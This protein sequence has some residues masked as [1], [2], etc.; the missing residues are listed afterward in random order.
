MTKTNDWPRTEELAKKTQEQVRIPQF[1]RMVKRPGTA[2]Y[3]RNQIKVNT[4][5]TKKLKA[6][7]KSALG[8]NATSV[9]SPGLN[10]KSNSKSRTMKGEVE[11]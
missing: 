5:Q 6:T 9:E 4:S 11:H 3:S 8:L 7:I 2:Q 10:A 1:K